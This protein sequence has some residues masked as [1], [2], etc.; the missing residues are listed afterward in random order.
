M[1]SQGIRVIELLNQIPQIV[2]D[3]IGLEHKV[4]YKAKKLAGQQ[5]FQLLLYGLLSGKELSLRIL[6]ELYESPNE[7]Q[8]VQHA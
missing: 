2:F 7:Q 8:T 3:S 1:K 6:E 5:V 4:D